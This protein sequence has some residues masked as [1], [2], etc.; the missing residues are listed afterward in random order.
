MIESIAIVL[1]LSI[2]ISFVAVPAVWQKN[3][4]VFHG[5]SH[6]LILPFVISDIFSINE[7]L[8]SAIFVM[9]FAFL[10]VKIPSSRK[11]DADMIINII[12][13]AS[14]LIAVSLICLSSSRKIEISDYIFGDFISISHVDLIVMTII[15]AIK[16]FISTKYKGFEVISAVDNI[17][18]KLKYGKNIGKIV[19]IDKIILCYATYFSMKALGPILSSAI[20]ILLVSSG[21]IYAKS[22]ISMI[23]LTFIFSIISIGLGFVSSRVFDI[24]TS[25]T[26]AMFTFAIFISCFLS[27]S[28]LKR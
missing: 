14:T 7:V 27:S 5:L 13:N 16:I 23:V 28:F 11:F 15:M 3:G 21:R 2:S 17:F 19:F 8:V 9:I 25:P 26:I 10:M 18:M 6:A 22:V 20:I 4:N 12:Y 1:L 24:F